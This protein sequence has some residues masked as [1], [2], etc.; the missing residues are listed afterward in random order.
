MQKHTEMYVLDSYALL[1]LFKQ[2]EGWEEVKR[3][4]DEA[5]Q[6]KQ[7]LQMSLINWGEVLYISLVSSGKER[8][9]ATERIINFFPISIIP[10]D[11]TIT[12]LAAEFKATGGIS[13]ADCFAAAL[14]IEE[15][16]TLVTGDPE[17]KR[18]EKK[19]LKVLWI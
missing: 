10:P 9:E 17:F 11:Q 14:A 13:Y 19:G 8:M 16:A 6:T 1:V 18:L 15:D 2:Q 7:K 12:R 3:L 5:E 4:L